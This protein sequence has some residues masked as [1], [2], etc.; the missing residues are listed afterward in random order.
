MRYMESLKKILS[1][2]IASC[3]LIGCTKPGGE[4]G[5]N[6]DGSTPTVSFAVNPVMVPASGGT[7]TASVV[8]NSQW[9]AVSQAEWIT[10]VEPIEG[11]S[12]VSFNVAVNPDATPRDG[13]ITFSFEGSSY[14]KDLTIR[15]A[16]NL[17]TLIVTPD[18][19]TL[20]AEGEEK[21]IVVTGEDW[22]IKSI[23]ADWL[24]VEKKN[25]SAFTVSAPINYSGSDL[26]ADI[27]IS[28]ASGSS[29]TVSVSQE[30]DSNLFKGASTVAGRRFVYKSAGLVT[31]VTSDKSYDMD[32]NVSV[33][34]I[35]YKGQVNGSSRPTA[36]FV[37]EISLSDG[38]SLKMTCASD[39]DSSVGR[40]SSEETKVQILREQLSA[41]QAGHQELTVFGG[42][43]GD[44]FLQDDNNL[45]HGVFYRDGVCLKNTF[46]GGKQCNVFAIMNDGTAKI[47]TQDTYDNNKASILEGIGGRQQ[48]LAA[49]ANVSNDETLEPR[50]AVGVSSD[51]RTVWLIVVDGRNTLWSAGASYPIMAKMFLALGAY[52][53]INLDGGGSSTFVTADGGTFKTINKVTDTAG[54]RPVVNG[55]AIVRNK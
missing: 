11:N 26:E 19:V 10:S 33:M 32:K 24:E 8:S 53:A 1:F 43:N 6:S 48:I 16:A 17:S 12:G 46:D 31:S 4:N 2:V 39:D 42:V 25:S 41:F 21:D 13:K 7:M 52:N 20:S 34:E 29:V 55:I 28:D 5:G 18:H 37:Y 51:G 3:I 14:T 27:I 45:L 15:Q 50:T 47:I 40:T 38:V 30:F 44:F 22:R 35:C 36:L 49:G 9:N 23:S 54:E